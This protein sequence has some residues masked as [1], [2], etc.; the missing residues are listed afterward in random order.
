MLLVDGQEYD[1]KAIVAVAHKHLPGDGRPLRHDELSGGLGDAV[2][3]LMDLNFQVVPR[4]A[5]LL[6]HS[7]RVTG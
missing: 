4:S 3:K 6:G 7:G 2:R 5:R 1:S